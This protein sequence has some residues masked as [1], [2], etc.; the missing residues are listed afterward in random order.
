M[1]KDSVLVNG[2]FASAPGVLEIIFTATDDTLIKAVT[3]SNTTEI[4]ASYVLNIVPS[5]GDVSKPEIPFRVVPRLRSD[6][7]AE[8]INHVIPKGGTL[9]ISTSA[10]NSI[11]FRVSGRALDTQ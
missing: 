2:V 4:N 3:A 9:R 5:S 6:T 10:A 1:A 11:A 8:V 7:A